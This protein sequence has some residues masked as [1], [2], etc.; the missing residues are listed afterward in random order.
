MM[1]MRRATENLRMT[2]IQNL[3]QEL[4]DQLKL[5][6]KMD[7]FLHAITKISSSVSKEML[8]RYDKWMK[9]FGSI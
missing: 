1:Q 8:E 5:P 7:D 4:Q 2:Q 3:P 9:D 6:T